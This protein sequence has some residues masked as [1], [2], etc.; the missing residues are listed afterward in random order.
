[1]HNPWR[2]RIIQE[3]LYCFVMLL[4]AAKQ[5]CIQFRRIVLC[6]NKANVFYFIRR[7]RF[8]FYAFLA[9]CSFVCGCCILISFS[10]LS[11]ILLPK[12]CKVRV[13]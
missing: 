1:M 3:L 6:G 4:C 5:L 9:V 12:F 11:S 13:D 8:V 10:Q 2:S 7:V